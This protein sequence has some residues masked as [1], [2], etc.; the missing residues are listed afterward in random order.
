MSQNIFIGTDSGATTTKFAGVWENG[1]AIS[2]KILQ[3]P[4]NSRTGRDAVIAAGSAAISD[5]LAQNDLPW[6]QVQGVGLAIPGPYERYG[7]MGQ[8]AEPARELLRLGCACGLQR[9]ARP[10]SRP[11]PAADRG[12]R[13][14]LRRRG[15]GADCAR[16]HASLRADAHARLRPRRAFVGQD[17]LPLAGDT[18]AGMEAGHMP[19]PLHLL[20]LTGKPFPCGCGRTGAASRPTP[21]FPACRICWRKNC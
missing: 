8:V 5:F 10:A 19:A 2:T 6:S 15:R 7:V 11:P 21:P 4:T 17:G 12:Q 20:G 16:Q 13:R 1:E 18:L 3:R 14:Q 9:G